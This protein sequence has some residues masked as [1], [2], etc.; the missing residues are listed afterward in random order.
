MNQR[1]VQH[2]LDEV[3]QLRAEVEQLRAE[4]ETCQQVE[5]ALRQSTLKL[6]GIFEAFPDLLAM[7]DEQILLAVREITDR[8]RAEAELRQVNDEME[9]L[10]R[11]LPDLKFRLDAAGTILDYRAGQVM[12][13]YLPP[14]GF[15]GQ[16]MQNV[17]PPSVGH[18]FDR[19]IDRVHLA[20]AGGHPAL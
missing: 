19:A 7:P 15:M 6:E 13:L 11:A 12:D 2:L 3:E 17:L 8:K 10:F 14:E 20:H 1:D 4:V 9:S 16:R 18:L 5:K